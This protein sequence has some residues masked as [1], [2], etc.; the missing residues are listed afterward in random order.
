MARLG[1]GVPR[2]GSSQRPTSVPVALG[3][4][5]NVLNLQNI[6]Q[7]PATTFTGILS[8][9]VTI[10]GIL[11]QNGVLGPHVGSGTATVVTLIGAI[12]GALV[13]IIAKDPNSS[14]QPK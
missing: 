14:N 10:W 6:W 7:H 9:I 4:E 11:A 12:A 2:M 5:R 8:A 13:A 3:K 1:D